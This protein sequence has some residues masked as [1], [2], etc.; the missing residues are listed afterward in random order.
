MKKRNGFVSNS[1]SSSFVVV[2]NSS[3]DLVCK[4]NNREFP[5]STIV[6]G[7]YSS[8]FD[9]WND[10]RVFMKDTAR[11]YYLTDESDKLIDGE[12]CT[13]EEYLDAVDRCGPDWIGEAVKHLENGKTIAEFDVD[14]SDQFLR[15]LLDTVFDSDNV[16]TDD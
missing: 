5:L 3:D 16:L 14:Y 6:S 2:V 10:A 13:V 8:D 11:N 4:I 15:T 1:S 7:S 12:T 9:V